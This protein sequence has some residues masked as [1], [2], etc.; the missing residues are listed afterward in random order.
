[1]P[2]ILW[3][4]PINIFHPTWTL[5]PSQLYHSFPYYSRCVLLQMAWTTCLSLICSHKGQT[6]FIDSL[7]W[8]RLHTKRNQTKKKVEFYKIEGKAGV[9]EKFPESRIFIGIKQDC[10]KAY[11]LQSGFHFPIFLE[12]IKPRQTQMS[13]TDNLPLNLLFSMSMWLCYS[14]K[15]WRI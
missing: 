12:T 14:R 5:H 7:K 6:W 10:V 8:E 3:I 11:G 15:E 2:H 4:Y 1:M 9:S 13:Y